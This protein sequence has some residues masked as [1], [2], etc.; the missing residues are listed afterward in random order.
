VIRLVAKILLDESKVIELFKDHTVKEL[1]GIFNVSHRKIYNILHGNN[2]PVRQRMKPIPITK[3]ELV[4]LYINQG[5]G[6]DKIG[7]SH[8]IAEETV[9]KLLIRYQ[10]PI[11]SQSENLLLSWEKGNRIIHFLSGPDHPQWKGGK[12]AKKGYKMIKRTGHHHAGVDG[13]VMEHI[14]VW[15]EH[16]NKKLPK[17]WVI[18]HLNGIKDDNRPDNLIALPDRKHKRVLAEKAKKIRELELKV[19]ILERA[20]DSKQMLFWSES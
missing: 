15:E 2:I 13:Y 3:E 1:S 18:H 7:K 11:R 5:V 10:V 9:K 6:M 16:N 20:L 17:G 19:K 8:H 12:R 4:D 14:L